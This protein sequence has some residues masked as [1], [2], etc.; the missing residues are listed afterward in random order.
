MKQIYN[1]FQDLYK[2]PQI[3]LLVNEERKRVVE[4][5]EEEEKLHWSWT[6][7]KVSS[8]SPLRYR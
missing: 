8:F 6:C 3:R 4:E 2:I 7:G 1:S 5:L